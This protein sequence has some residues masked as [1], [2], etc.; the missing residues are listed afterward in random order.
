MRGKL[1]LIAGALAV[2]TGIGAGTAGVASAKDQG[3]PSTPAVV[4]PTDVSVAESVRET[5][6]KDDPLI[7]GKIDVEASNGVVVLSGYVRNDNEKQ[8]A[9][10]DAKKVPGVTAVK[11]EMTLSESDY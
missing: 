4:T 8:Q 1:W 11:D 6:A 5:L 3:N 10:R 9:I 2:A 7:L